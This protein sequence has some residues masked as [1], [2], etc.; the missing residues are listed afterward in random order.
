MCNVVLY[1]ECSIGRNTCQLHSGP[2][3]IEAAGGSEEEEQG[4][5]GS[6][7]IPHQ[8]PPVGVCQLPD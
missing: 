7:T 1:N 2:D 4:R 8:G 5:Y 3:S 6:E